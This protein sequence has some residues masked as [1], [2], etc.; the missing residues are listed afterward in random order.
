MAA[1]S[2][3][4]Y[5]ASTFRERF[6]Q[7]NDTTTEKFKLDYEA[8]FCIR[9][10][11]LAPYVRFP[12][13]P[14]RQLTHNIIFVTQA[15]HT[16]RIGIE[17]YQIRPNQMIVIQAGKVFSLESLPPEIKG[18]GCCFHPSMLA[19]RMGYSNL[20]E[21]FEFLSLWGTSHIHFSKEG[22][23][24]I[25]NLLERM[26][27]EYAKNG[28]QNKAL[29]QSY[30]ITLLSEIKN[31]VQEADKAAPKNKIDQTFTTF[32]KLVHQHLQQ[33]YQISDFAKLLHI[34]PN[35]LNKITKK[36]TG[37]TASNFI[38]QMKILEAKCLLYQTDLTIG[39][40]A[41]AI[42]YTDKNYFTRVFRKVTGISPSQYR[43]D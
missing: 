13:L 9:L 30:L 43:K 20:Q 26:A 29:L 41:T 34:T 32:K 39:E 2:I 12:I 17:E 38:K 4:N 3:T 18:F 8:F 19:E 35:H 6:L 24:F 23:V 27:K 28:I 16:S 14:A 42:G 25:D 7:K 31:S 11:E 40:I 36:I 10:E 21:E 33:S 1:K 37:Q 5:T 15:V 22:A